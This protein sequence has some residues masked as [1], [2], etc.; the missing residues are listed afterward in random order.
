MPTVFSHAISAFALGK[1]LRQNWPLLLL[2][3]FCAMLPDGDVIGF[4]LGIPYGS[5]FGH[6]GFTHSPFF[7]FLLAALLTVVFYRKAPNK[8]LIFI[9]LFLC[10]ASHGVLDAM[11]SGGKGIAFLAPFSEERF[12][13][14]YRPIKVS[15]I[16]LSRFLSEWGLKVM[17][18]EFLYIW[19]PSFLLI[20]LSYLMNRVRK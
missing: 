3:M 13:M 1:V 5:L 17:K 16:G 20:G 11:T 15:P 19:I 7:A 6:R 9:Y 12:F 4:N 18:S 14:P 2:G 10:T 8:V